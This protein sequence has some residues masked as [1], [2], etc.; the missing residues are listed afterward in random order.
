VGTFLGI[1]CLF[2]AIWNKQVESYL[3]TL[4]TIRSK[5]II[6]LFKFVFFT[7]IFCIPLLIPTLQHHRAKAIFGKENLFSAAM[8]VVT[9]HEFVMDHYAEFVDLSRVYD[10]VSVIETMADPMQSV[11]LD[12]SGS[13]FSSVFVNNPKGGVYFDQ[14]LF[15][16]CL[17]NYFD[18]YLSGKE[19][20]K[21]VLAE[22]SKQDRKKKKELTALDRD[23]I[24]DASDGYK[25]LAA[26]ADTGFY[27]WL[28][29]II[30]WALL[31]ELRNRNDTMS[32]NIN[33]LSVGYSDTSFRGYL[34]A[35]REHDRI[36]ADVNVTSELLSLNSSGYTGDSDRIFVRYP[37]KRDYQRYYDKICKNILNS[38]SIR[39]DR[40]VERLGI[41]TKHVLKSIEGP[42]ID[43]LDFLT[44]I[45]ILS[46]FF[47]NIMLLN[48]IKG[49]QI[50]FRI[51]FFLLIL[52][53]IAFVL[54]LFISSEI[55]GWAGDHLSGIFTA[56]I[57]LLSY[58]FLLLFI[59]SGN[60][61]INKF[62][63]YLLPY[64]LAVSSFS[65][66]GIS[67]FKDLLKHFVRISSSTSSD[68][69]FEIAAEIILVMT[70]YAAAKKVI[71]F[72]L[73]PQAK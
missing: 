61:F 13:R 44:V 16:K 72:Y 28:N 7:V 35:K 47:C 39:S 20:T 8:P 14:S 70:V 11:F 41:R 48:N 24:S 42:Q 62:Q 51:F 22:Y 9:N 34:K 32:Y 55:E 15:L 36:F 30:P 73:S 54:D 5:I 71:V 25:N 3:S 21:A 60:S 38:N 58:V 59:L 63:N 18:K 57:F 12:T 29:T 23:S 4:F 37:Q 19:S 6:Y 52:L 69:Y 53:V 43:Y 68:F 46:A 65:P 2:S 17:N 26:L 45:S 33:L 49:V 56:A 1:N 64:I 27:R 66:L 40:D 31:K 67:L 10:T 50:V